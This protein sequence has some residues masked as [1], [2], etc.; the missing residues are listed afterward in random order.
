MQEILTPV[1]YEPALD[2]LNQINKLEISHRARITLD[3]MQACKNPVGHGNPIIGKFCKEDKHGALCCKSV[4]K[5]TNIEIQVVVNLA[6]VSQYSTM[7]F[8]NRIQGLMCRNWAYNYSLYTLYWAIP[9]GSV[10]KSLPYNTFTYLPFVGKEITF[11]LDSLQRY[12][13]ICYGIYE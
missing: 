13:V 7:E 2:V 1:Q 4:E 9:E 10:I 3:A 6:R 8:T 11:W 5:F 12:Y